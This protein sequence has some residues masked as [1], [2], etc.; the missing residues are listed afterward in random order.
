M[1]NNLPTA[2]S[3]RRNNVHSEISARALARW[4]PSIQAAASET[5]TISILDAIGYDYWT[6]EGFSAKRAEAALRSI[7]EDTPVDVVI[8]SPGGDMFE[9]LAIYNLFREH[10]APV[11]V[12]VI[13]VAASAASVIA[14]AGDTVEIARAGFFMIHNSWVLAAGNRHDLREISDWLEPFDDVMADIYAARTGMDKK[15]IA[16]LM[17]SESW[18]GGQSAVDDGFADSLLASDDIEQRE[19]AKALSS[20]RRLEGALR[21]SGMPK[22]EAMSLI[23]D[24]KSAL[25]DPVGS[26][27]GDPTERGAAVAL[28]ETAALAESLKNLI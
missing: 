2:P 16:K 12:K 27:T 14:M 3:A 13:G 17:D 10:K 1:R 9:G 25:G 24:F 15:A 22:S 5:A 8:N 28:K 23:S 7:G 19:G 6:G 4:N 26:G 20:V 11:N 18:I 21:A